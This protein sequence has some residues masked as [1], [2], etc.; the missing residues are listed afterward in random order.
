MSKKYWLLAIIVFC[1]IS[2]D[3]VSAQ[4]EYGCDMADMMLG[5][6][7]SWMMI[8]VWAFGLLLLVALILFIVWLVKQIQK[9]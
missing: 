6:Y 4:T 2:T 8:F 1:L 3:F 9:Q 5:G 7:G